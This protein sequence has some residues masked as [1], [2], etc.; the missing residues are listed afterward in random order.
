MIRQLL[1]SIMK[2][3]KKEKKQQALKNRLDFA[4]SQNAGHKTGHNHE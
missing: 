3:K 2:K 4:M 1:A